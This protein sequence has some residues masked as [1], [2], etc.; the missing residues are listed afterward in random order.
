MQKPPFDEIAG[1]LEELALPEVK[2][3]PRRRAEVCRRALAL[4]SSEQPWHRSELW[5]ELGDALLVDVSDRR[6]DSVEEAIRCFQAALAEAPPDLPR[7][8]RAQLLIRLGDSYRNRLRGPR[9]DNV[10]EALRS[11]QEALAALDRETEAEAWAL[12]QG[13]RGMAWSER[14]FGDRAENV[15]LAI[16]AYEQALEVFTRDRF[17]IE[18][19]V[20][21][22]NLANVYRDRLRGDPA[23]NLDHAIQLYERALEV[24]SRESHE[25]QWALTVHNL[26]IACRRRRRGNPED[27]VDRSIDLALQ[28]LQV[29]TRESAPL[30]WAQTQCTLG[31]AWA[32]RRRGDSIENLRRAQEAYEG[33]LEVMTPALVPFKAATILRNLGKIRGLL[34]LKHGEGAVEAA[35][36]ACHAA[37]EIHQ[38][39]TAPHE[40]REAADFLGT[41]LF[42]IP[43]WNDAAAAFSSALRAGELLY[44][45]GATPE[46]R[47]VE[48]RE[49]GDLASRA[50]YCLARAGH[51]TEAVETLEKSR[52]RALGESLD[53]DEALLERIRDD[54]RRVFRE[55]RERIRALEAEA[56][57][58]GP[59]GSRGF[60]EIS[61]DLR[62]VRQELRELTETI[63]ASVPDFLEEG[64]GF[65]GI[66][67]LAARLKRPLVQLVNVSWGGLA[68]IIPPGAEGPQH[69]QAVWMRG[70]SH[71]ETQELLFA[72]DH[73]LL[74]QEEPDS[75]AV[76][77]ALARALPM[78]QERFVTPV[79]EALLALGFD[80]GILLPAGFLSL[81]PLPALAAERVLLTSAPSA[82]LLQTA[83]SRGRERRGA[84]L[85]FLGVGTAAPQHPLP[86]ARREIEGAAAAFSTDRRQLLLGRDASRPAT[87]AGMAGASHLHFA[88]HGLFDPAAPLESAL[89]LADGERLT[90]RDLLDGSPDLS[91]AQLAVLSACRSGL[92][93]YRDTPD[94][95]LG[96]PAVLL[97]AGIPAVIGTLWPV[98]DLSS[99]LLLDRFYKIH[100]REGQAAGEALRS[101]QRWLC[102]AT[103]A[104]LGLA[105][106]AEELLAQARTS[107]KRAA[108][109]Q[110]LRRSRSRPDLCPYS[111]PY[112]WAG[113]FLTGDP[114]EE[115]TST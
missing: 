76:K 93:E 6:P 1:L 70:L 21:A 40:H 9:A 96:F 75:E 14:V 4:V 3:S 65:A 63:R 112:Y 37:L 2:H 59:A 53:R 12:L 39:E 84:P 48:L 61:S 87:F 78:L 60:L 20:T 50:A 62:A 100:L 33:G 114:G 74:P 73:P 92:V 32:E 56:R 30:R 28:A 46:S 85:A 71:D 35:L 43:R 106:R 44:Q 49:G 17:P 81:L 91:A 51:W 98:A 10:E 22:N 24:R 25:V 88:C 115:S 26:A 8:K 27:N 23:D 103:A 111:H 94:E 18:W 11:Y 79:A 47:N 5:R 55:L 64:L 34:Y 95:A 42:G 31:N 29:R 77:A 52:T 72:G 15:E 89:H 67:G 13:S 113:Y 83:V 105:D 101:A 97:Q 102:Q 41:I 108:A 45:A 104:E 57:S 19:A 68:L 99:A 38:A 7:E 58:T 36:S 16:A 90:V 80:R 54:H 109:Y 107:G 86:F 82:R 69:V 66:C 110:L